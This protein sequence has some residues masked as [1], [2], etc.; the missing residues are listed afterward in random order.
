MEH[1]LFIGCVGI[2]VQFKMLGNML[3]KCTKAFNADDLKRNKTTSIEFKCKGK[4]KDSVPL[5][6]PRRNAAP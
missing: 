6:K 4:D 3:Q 1:L 5:N 2:C